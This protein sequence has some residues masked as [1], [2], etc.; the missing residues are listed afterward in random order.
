[1]IKT[2]AWIEISKLQLQK[3]LKL[4]CQDMPQNVAFF[5]VVKDNA[6]GHDDVLFSE[7]AIEAGCSYLLTSCLSEALKIRKYFPEFPIMILYERF[8]D[9]LSLCIEKKFTIVIQNLSKVKKISEIAEKKNMTAKVHM[10]VDTG[11]R[12]YGIH[13]E[14]ASK[15]YQQILQ[16]PALDV[17]GIMTHFSQSDEND[18]SFA[19]LQWQRFKNTLN[20]IKQLHLELPR[21][22]HC[23]NSGGYLDLPQCHYN[24][25]RIGILNTGIY[26]SKVCR[27]IQHN[28]ECLHPVLSVKT[29]VAMLKNIQKNDVVGYGMKY[30]AQ[31]NEKIAIIPF[32][33]GDGFPRIVNK[34]KVLINGEFAPII[35]GCAMDTIMVNITHI[36]HVCVNDE[37]TI[38]GQQHNKK[39][40]IH[41]LGSWLPTVAYD[42]LIQWNQR[43]ERI[44]TNTHEE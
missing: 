22:I 26:P 30:T 6:F 19:L 41:D 34:G 14:H 40:T 44:Y 36:P 31:Q 21:Y 23:C 11:M 24:A 3:N 39:I 20:E 7:Q 2:R 25:V 29:R 17:E 8:D 32:G 38:I 9:E 12:R 16:L 5:C 42:T 4:I 43:L 18:K 13:W 15:L 10:K 35:G 27:R 28:K 37:V 1:M 33:Y